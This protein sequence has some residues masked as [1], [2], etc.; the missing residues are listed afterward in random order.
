MDVFKKLLFLPVDGNMR[1]AMVEASEHES[2]ICLM[3]PH[4]YYSA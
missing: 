3:I 4:K 2:N 1:P